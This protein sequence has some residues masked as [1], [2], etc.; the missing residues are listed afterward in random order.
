MRLGAKWQPRG[1]KLLHEFHVGNVKLTLCCELLARRLATSGLACSLLCACH[2]I[3][4]Y[5]ETRLL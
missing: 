3:K 5:K 2:F 4:V 1:V